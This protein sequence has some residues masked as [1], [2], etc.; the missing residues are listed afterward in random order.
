[1]KLINGNEA[2]CRDCG[3]SQGVVIIAYPPPSPPHCVCQAC[4]SANLRDVDGSIW[5]SRWEEEDER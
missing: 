3:E 2:R 4:G 1:M 5:I